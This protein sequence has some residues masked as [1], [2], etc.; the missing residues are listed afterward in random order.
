ME[1]LVLSCGMGG[2]HNAAGRAVAE[3]LERR[4]HSVVF[5]NAFR[6]NGDRVASIVNGAYIKIAQR[7]PRLFG[8]IYMLGNAYRKLPVKSPVYW[9]NGKMTD[10]VEQFLLKHI[11]DA[12][13]MTHVFPAQTFAKL[14][15]NHVRIPKTY[16]VATDYT[17]I[18]FLEETDCDYCIIPSKEL[19]Q[20]FCDYGFQEERLLPYGIPVG[21]A[22]FE[23]ETKE[24]ARK[25]LGLYR[26]G[27]CMLLSGGS[28][29]AGKLPKAIRVLTEVLLENPKNC[30]IVICGNN[31]KLY[32]KLHKRY[33]NQTQIR[34]LQK[35][36]DMAEYMKAS[37]VLIS[38]PGGLTSTEAAASETP[39][40][41][42][43]PI[44]GCETHNMEFF[45]KH[46]MSIAVG[47]LKKELLPAV[48]KLQSPKGAWDMKKAQRMH[49]NRF[50]VVDLCDK[51]E[52]EISK[53]KEQL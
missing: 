46:G 7:V 3:E 49:S 17:C 28:I 19:T 40:I 20:E 36:S 26:D 53:Q 23:E 9:A 25:R 34:L 2:G 50:A 24:E 6:L 42:I 18:P 12:V 44:P 32:Q 11:F 31:Q 27:F 51:I 33:G 30:L 43:S 39:L 35:T 5:M 13:V 29:G 1:V 14:K 8:L 22:F 16:L 4:G 15:E 45:E 52:Q 37:D 41:H 10:S 48:R 47:N 21:R 38:K